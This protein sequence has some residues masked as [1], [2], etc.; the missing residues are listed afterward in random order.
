MLSDEI[1][2][3]DNSQDGDGQF[4]YRTLTKEEIE[5]ALQHIDGSRFPMNLANARAA[6][7]ARNSGASPEPAPILDEA[8]DEKYTYRAE[9]LLGVLIAAYAAIGLGFDDLAIPYWGR[10]VYV[11]MHGAGVIHLHGSAAWMGALAMVFFAAIPFFG[12][13]G[14]SDNLAIVPRF[15]YVYRAAVVILMVAVAMGY[16]NR[17]AHGI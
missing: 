16:L 12:G 7:E 3:L 4:D 15:K 9:K 1:V 6:L 13:L 5:Y 17:S 10:H 14:D 2:S 11:Q 8:T